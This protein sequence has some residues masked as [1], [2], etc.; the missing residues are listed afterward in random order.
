MYAPIACS[1]SSAVALLVETAAHE[2]AM[3]ATSSSA[4][5]VSDS[6]GLLRSC[7][8]SRLIFLRNLSSTRVLASDLES[9]SASTFPEILRE[10]AQDDTKAQ[11]RDP[12]VLFCLLPS[13]ICPPSV[14]L[15]AANDLPR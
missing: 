9:R 6:Q 10:Y 14:I 4:Q 3:N 15:A 5:M 11:S 12:S 7:V 1:G 2:I 13:D 8:I